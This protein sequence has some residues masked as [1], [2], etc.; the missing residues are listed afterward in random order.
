MK[1][2]KYI[3]EIVVAAICSFCAYYLCTTVD[4]WKEDDT[5]FYILTI[6]TFIMFAIVCVCDIIE[7][8]YNIR[9]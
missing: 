2:I 6:G 8:I 7:S 3:I 9:K 4:T 1:V 5:I